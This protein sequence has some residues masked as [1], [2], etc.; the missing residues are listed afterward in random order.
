MRSVSETR[1]CLRRLSRGQRVLY[2]VGTL[3]DT[4]PSGTSIKVPAGEG[5]TYVLWPVTEVFMRRDAQTEKRV[6]NGAVVPYYYFY[7]DQRTANG[8]TGNKRAP[9]LKLGEALVHR[10]KFDTTS[11]R[12][13]IHT[14][15]RN[16]KIRHVHK[17]KDLVTLVYVNKTS[18]EKSLLCETCDKIGHPAYDC[19]TRPRDAHES[20][21]IDVRSLNYGERWNTNEL[22]RTMPLVPFDTGGGG[23]CLFRC[24]CYMLTGKQELESVY[25]HRVRKGID[26]QFAHEK[27]ESKR[28]QRQ[29]NDDIVEDTALTLRRLTCAYLETYTVQGKKHGTSYTDRTKMRGKRVFATDLEISALCN[30]LNARI[31]VYTFDENY[32]DFDNQKSKCI[33]LNMFWNTHND[34]LRSKTPFEWHISLHNHNQVHYVPFINTAGTLHNYDQEFFRSSERS[35]VSINGATSPYEITEMLAGLDPLDNTPPATIRWLYPHSS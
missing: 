34:D 8:D 9:A 22:V 7:T 6:D 11:Y 13:F 18:G 21:P 4:H 28:Q 10:L 33:Q 31:D 12:Y 17:Q 16:A 30:L 32:S 19:P 5:R 14:Q 25:E 27:A 23:E 1:S 20:G 24:I 29:W 26:L 15:A 2:R 3:A 35:V